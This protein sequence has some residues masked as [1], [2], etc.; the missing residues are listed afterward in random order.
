[1]QQLDASGTPIE[2]TRQQTTIARRMKPSDLS[3][4]LYDTRLL[5]DESL[6]LHYSQEL[7]GKA[8]SLRAWVEVWP[9]EAYRRNY[10]S[11]LDHER[12]ES[13]HDQLEK[14]MQASIDS[15]YVLWTQTLSL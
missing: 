10:K 13:G 8:D 5:P 4:E 14:A 3:V 7:H 15:R 2:G 6:T 9:D 11:W 12:F 1:M